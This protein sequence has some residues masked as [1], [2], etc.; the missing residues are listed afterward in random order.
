MIPR[1]AVWVNGYADCC[2]AKVWG[3]DPKGVLLP[4]VSSPVYPARSPATPA[5]R[6]GGT[7]APRVR[8]RA[9]GAGE[10]PEGG[11]APRFRRPG[12]SLVMSRSAVRVGSSALGSVVPKVNPEGGPRLV[13]RGLLTPLSIGNNGQ[14]CLRAGHVKVMEI[15]WEP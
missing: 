5:R 2:S 3:N 12:G 8:L 13:I 9:V 11:A 15:E 10:G 7:P 1:R 6:P 14:P 4:M